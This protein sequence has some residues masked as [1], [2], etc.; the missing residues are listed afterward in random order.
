MADKRV[1]VEISARHVHL[2]AE[3]LNRLFGEGFVLTP[4]RALSQPGQFLAEERLHVQGPAGAFDSV[5]ILAPMRSVTQVE[6]SLSDGRKLG[7]DL[8][9]RPSGDIKGSAGVKLIGPKG[10]LILTEGAIAAKRHVH[11]S[12]EDAACFGLRNGQIISARIS[13]ARALVFEEVQVRVD[14]AFVSAMHVDVDEANA[15][16]ISGPAEAELLI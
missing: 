2:T 5:A 15:A 6:L 16:G 12:P 3:H 7:I 13:G 9:V 4:R 14:P 11:L 1:P 10:A 8:P